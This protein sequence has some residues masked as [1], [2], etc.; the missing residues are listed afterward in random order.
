MQLLKDIKF[1]DVLFVKIKTV[2]NQKTLQ[3]G[4]DDYLVWKD[5]VDRYK[6]G[7]NV[8]VFDNYEEKSSFYPEFS[9]IV[10]ITTA[11]IKEGRMSVKTYYDSDEC[12][13]IKSFMRD[14]GIATKKRPSL[15]LC[16]H[17]I[18]GFDM[19]FL[20]KRSIVNR[21]NPNKLIDVGGLKP[22][23][24]TCLDTNEIW[25][26]TGFY[27]CSLMTLCLALG[28]KFSD[29]IS[30]AELADMFYNEEIEGILNKC[31]E[32]VISVAQCYLAMRFDDLISENN[33][34]FY[35]VAEP[36]PEGVIQRIS[37]TGSVSDVDKKE[38]L[39]K[40]KDCTY[41]EKEIVIKMVKAALAINKVE[42]PEE[43]ELEMLM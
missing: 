19:P 41:S 9:R 15:R 12:N 32:E 21:I 29:K 25:K 43:L 33:I 7:D 40:L 37:N 14:L 39:F 16:G 4:S 6:D 10:C 17:S 35:E 27:S 30:E 23:E 18:K 34:S 5:K 20:F 8:D 36:E 24:V 28:V 13:L 38:L 11:F 2:R 22:W 1:E 31:Q 42:M 26:A 3:E